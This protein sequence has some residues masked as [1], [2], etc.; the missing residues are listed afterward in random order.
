MTCDCVYV[1]TVYTY[2]G[3]VLGKKEN[4]DDAYVKTGLSVDCQGAMKLVILHFDS[5]NALGFDEKQDEALNNTMNNALAM[6][7]RKS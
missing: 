3:F 2:G 5:A 6:D 1:C 7:N 4:V